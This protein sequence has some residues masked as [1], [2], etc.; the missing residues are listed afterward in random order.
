MNR[1]NIQNIQLA[2]ESCDIYQPDEGNC[3][4]CLTKAAEEQQGFPILYL[5]EDDSI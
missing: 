1:P 5:P 2:C 3:R 4:E